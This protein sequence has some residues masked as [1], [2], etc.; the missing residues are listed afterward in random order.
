MM[1]TFVVLTA[2]VLALDLITKFTIPGILNPGVA[3]GVGANVSWLWIVIV[4]FSFALVA[5]AVWWF[6]HTKHRTWLLTIGL[7]LF[8]G[9]VL[10]NAI[11]RLVTGGAVHDFIDFVIFKNNLADMAIIAGATMV[12]VQIALR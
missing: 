5:M 12:G 2:A 7:A 1:L 9:G 8:V 6:G 10:G 4:V 11:D 3:W